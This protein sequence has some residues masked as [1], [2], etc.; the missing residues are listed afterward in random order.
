[1]CQDMDFEHTNKCERDDADS[2]FV[3][4]VVLRTD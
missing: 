2:P 3:W 4:L 1:M